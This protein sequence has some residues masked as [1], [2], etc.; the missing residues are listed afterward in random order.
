MVDCHWPQLSIRDIG[1]TKRCMKH[2]RVRHRHDGLNG[3]FGQ[4][5]VVMSSHAS[6]L[7][8][9]SKIFQ[10]IC[11]LVICEANLCCRSSKTVQLRHDLGASFRI[12][13]W[14]QEFRALSFQ[15]ACL[16]RWLS[17]RDQ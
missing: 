16:Q 11:V 7:F 6:E 9:L 1:P 13:V 2:H 8:D 15:F 4:S 10:L 12:P 5:I 17:K 14:I 3:L